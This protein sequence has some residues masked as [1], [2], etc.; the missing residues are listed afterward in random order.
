MMVSTNFDIVEYVDKNVYDRFGDRAIQFIDPRLIESVQTLRD[1]LGVPLIINNWFFGGNRSQSGL[2]TPN[3]SFYTIFSQHSM[4]RA[5]DIISKH[6]SPQKLRDHIFENIQAYPHIK[7]IELDVPWLHI[8]VRN[9]DEL[10]AF[11][12]S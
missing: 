5:A 7:G 10:L 8:D 4:G 3:M 11:R 12:P 9:L 1:N 2:R 6:K